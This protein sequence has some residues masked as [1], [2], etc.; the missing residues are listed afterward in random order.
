MIALFEN[1]KVIRENVI[2]LRAISLLIVFLSQF[3]SDKCCPSD[4]IG[5]AC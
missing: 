4:I 3:I 2:K 1:L 5:L